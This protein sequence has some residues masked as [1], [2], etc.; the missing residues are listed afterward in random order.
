LEKYFPDS[1]RH[2][3]EA[4]FLTFQQGNLT[5][6]AYTDKFEYLARFYS[7]TVTEEWRCRKYEGR[8]KHELRPFDCTSPDQGVPSL[9]GAGHGYRA[10]GNGAQQRGSTSKDYL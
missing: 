2:E 7:P 3:R 10:A 6:Q 9:G 4:E 1:A 8:L 5:V